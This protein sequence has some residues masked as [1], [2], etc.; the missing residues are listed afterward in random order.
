V[1]DRLCAEPGSHD[2]AALTVLAALHAVARPAFVVPPQ[3]F[4]PPPKVESAVFRRVVRVAFAQRRKTLKNALRAGFGEASATAWLAGA[5]IDGGRRAETL[6][7]AEFA[8]LARLAQTDAL[9]KDGGENADATPD[10]RG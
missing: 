5:A 3:A 2:Y 8:A 7:L 4:S 9:R 10:G 6:S 1:A